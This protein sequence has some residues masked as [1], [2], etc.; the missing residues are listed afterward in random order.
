MKRTILMLTVVSLLVAIPVIAKNNLPGD[1]DKPVWA[2]VD[3]I[4]I[5]TDEY[6]I[7]FD[8]DP[9]D[10]AVKYS[11]DIKG[12]VVYVD[13]DGDEGE[14]AL[15]A[16]V[17][18][19]SFGTS[20]RTDDGEMGDSDL[21]I[22]FDELAAAIADELGLVEGDLVL[23]LTDPS[24]LDPEDPEL[25]EACAKV[26]GLDPTRPS[27]KRQNNLFS[28]CEDLPDDITLIYEVPAPPA[29]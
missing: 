4:V 28:D 2:A 17:V 22:T 1:L 18:E 25:G 14:P 8:W 29:P 12:L 5:D 9:V 6:T 7:A 13:I 11:V 16:E 3:P 21:T 27:K 15:L 24:E 20:D 19:V 10:Y 26:K 23:G